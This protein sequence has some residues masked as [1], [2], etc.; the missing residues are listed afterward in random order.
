[1][2]N[3]WIDITQT[4]STRIATWPGDTPFEYEL[5]ATKKEG[6]AANVGTIKASLHT[7]THADAP[8]HYASEGETA[9]MLDVNLYIGRAKVVSVVGAS[10]IG[11]EE[12]KGFDLTGVERLLL[13]TT[14]TST[15]EKFPDRINTL[16]ENIG[17]FLKEKGIFL[18]GT[19][20]PSVDSIESKE[21]LAHH[22]L[23]KHNIYII[24]NLLLDNVEPGDYD[25]IALPLK[26]EGADGSPIRAVLRKVE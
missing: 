12:L 26:I 11:R 21:L 25:L 16:R 8:F 23:F 18:I 24:E 6:G 1:M 3:E 15:P 7:G 19:D 9:D 4:I 10:E 17:P 13:K 2:G 14:N 20:Q 5:T 22:S